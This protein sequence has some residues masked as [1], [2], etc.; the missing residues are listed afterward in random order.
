M[1]FFEKMN[2]D[3]QQSQELCRYLNYE[4]RKPE[5]VIFRRGDAGD[6]FYLL[7]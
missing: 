6:Q 7:L 2:I 3:Y 4:I 5:D 1:E